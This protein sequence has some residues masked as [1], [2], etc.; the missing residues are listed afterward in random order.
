MPSPITT[1]Q[2]D[3]P[4]SARLF[5]TVILLKGL[6][7][8]VEIFGG[9]ALLLLGPGR[10]I[11]GVYRITQDKISKDPNELVAKHLRDA[12]SHLSVSGEHFMAAYLLINGLVKVVLVV[13]LQRGQLWAYP[14]A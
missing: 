7:G 14:L 2:A 4:P 5:R 3:A 1:K 13:A 9:I 10:I 6:N 8:L 11:N 12:A